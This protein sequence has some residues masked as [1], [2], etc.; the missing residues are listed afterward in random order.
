M[1]EVDAAFAEQADLHLVAYA[2]LLTLL[3]REARLHLVACEWTEEGQFFDVYRAFGPRE[4]LIYLNPSLT[5][6]LPWRQIDGQP[7]L[8]VPVPGTTSEASEWLTQAIAVRVWGP[9][10]A[11]VYAYDLSY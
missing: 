1:R 5:S 7:R 4:P 11:P 6:L 3:P 2:R 9:D 10:H 8:L